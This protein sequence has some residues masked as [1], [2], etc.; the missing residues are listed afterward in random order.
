[1]Y[2]QGEYAQVIVELI[3]RDS[4]REKSRSKEK[5]NSLPEILVIPLCKTQESI[6]VSLHLAAW[7]NT[8]NKIFYVLHNHY[9]YTKLAFEILQG[10]RAKPSGVFPRTS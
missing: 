2:D 1:M 9:L 6:V 10:M 5:K 7:G 4:N 8:L 3:L